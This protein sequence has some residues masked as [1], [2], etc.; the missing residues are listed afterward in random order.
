MKNVEPDLV[1]K[2]KLSAA[3]RKLTPRGA[4]LLQHVLA[5][6]LI[7]LPHTQTLA[8]LDAVAAAAS[9]VTSQTPPDAAA[10]FV[11]F[12]RSAGED[13]KRD[14]IQ[15]AV[16]VLIAAD[17]RRAAQVALDAIVNISEASVDHGNAVFGELSPYRRA[18]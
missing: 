14:E 5:E 18:A 8:M 16:N 6:A 4:S 2:A 7:P 12:V 15:Q 10:A 11:Y 13:S 9:R 1:L 3:L 17:L